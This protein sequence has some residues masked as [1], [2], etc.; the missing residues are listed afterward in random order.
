VNV[1]SNLITVAPGQPVE[2]KVD[3]FVSSERP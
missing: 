2:V 1:G 3:I